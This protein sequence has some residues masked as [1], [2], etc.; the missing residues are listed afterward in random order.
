MRLYQF[1][2]APMTAQVKVTVPAG[3]SIKSIALNSKT[4]A[5]FRRALGAGNMKVE[6]LPDGNA[7]VTFNFAHPGY[8][9]YG[10]SYTVYL[11]VTPVSAAQTV[12]NTQLKFTVKSYK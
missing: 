2:S 9:T 4:P 10:K 12:K 3:A 7:L 8:L 1:Q 11:D 6:Y 5:Q